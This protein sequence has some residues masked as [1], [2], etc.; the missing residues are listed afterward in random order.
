LQEALYLACTGNRRGGEAAALVAFDRFWERLKKEL[1]RLP[2]PDPSAHVARIRKWSRHQEYF[3]GD[4]TLLYRGGSIISCNTATTDGGRRQISVSEI[5]QVYEVWPDY[6]AGRVRRNH[7]VHDLGVHNTS[8][9]IP[10]LREYERLM[11]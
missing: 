8:W 6:R 7:I 2:G 3:G 4:F 9:I 10:I 1:S 5:R 11:S